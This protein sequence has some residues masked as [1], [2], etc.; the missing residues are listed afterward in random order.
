MGLIAESFPDQVG[1]C[2]VHGVGEGFAEWDGV[3]LGQFVVFHETV[4]V[5]EFAVEGGY[6]ACCGEVSG[7]QDG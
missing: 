4:V 7:F 6:G 2:D 1:E 5:L 3:L